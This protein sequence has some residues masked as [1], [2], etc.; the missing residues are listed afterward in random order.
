M[1][2]A[3]FIL[4]KKF[5]TESLLGGGAVK[6]A[7]ATIQSI[8]PVEG[9]NEVTFEWALSDGTLKTQKMFVEN[10][11]DGKDGQ[12]G[13]DGKDGESVALNM[14]AVTLAAS[15]WIDGKQT[16]GVAGAIADESKQA[17]IPLPVK[18]SEDAFYNAKIRAYVPS[19][20]QIEFTAE[21]V[22][23]ENLFLHVAFFGVSGESTIINDTATSTS[24]VWSSKK[25]SDEIIAL[26]SQIDE[27]KA[28]LSG[29]T[30]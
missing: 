28:Q 23:A 26:Q 7:P 4:S 10:G 30:T 19:D 17:V 18:L 27:L 25:T 16:I 11:T 3:T 29:I 1:D 22:P 14:P 2:P 6:G 24:R 12:N 15:G 8:T 9:G 20:G 13:I 5:T 21:T